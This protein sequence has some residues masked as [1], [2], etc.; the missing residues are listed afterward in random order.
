MS[1]HTLS[2]MYSNKPCQTAMHRPSRS[3]ALTSD[4][5][6]N[7]LLI[8]PLHEYYSKPRLVEINS[9][10]Q[11][12]LI[13]ESEHINE[14]LEYFIRKNKREGEQSKIADAS[15]EKAGIT[16]YISGKVTIWRIWYRFSDKAITCWLLYQ[17]DTWNR[18]F[19]KS[20]W[21]SGARADERL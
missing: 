3:K 16:P 8:S 21:L 5:L 6:W 10:P 4:T 9:D 1:Q 7:F 12:T 18:R 17:K 20:G 15:I 2:K 14:V 13:S 11:V 19:Y